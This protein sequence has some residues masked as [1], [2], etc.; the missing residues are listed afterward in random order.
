M[1]NTD[2]GGAYIFS[3]HQTQ[4]PAYLVAGSPPA[5]VTFQGDIGERIRRISKQDSV[6]VNV[7][8]AAVFGKIF[9]D[10]ITLR[11][12]L[13]PGAPAATISASLADIDAASIAH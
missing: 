10:L 13:D 3:G 4:T 5:A 9:D 6:P 7:L 12:N 11:D 8:G 1:A 2:F